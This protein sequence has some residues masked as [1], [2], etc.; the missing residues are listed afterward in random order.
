MT[1]VETLAKVTV[2]LALVWI[3]AA[4]LRRQSAAARHA[5]WAA[6]LIG[7]VLILVLE[8]APGYNLLPAW[9][10]VVQ[11]PQE[12]PKPQSLPSPE[13]LEGRVAAQ[14]EPG[15]MVELADTIATRA[16]GPLGKEVDRGVLLTVEPP[17]VPKQAPRVVSG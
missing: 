15:R 9:S 2:F 13:E 4:L 12:S 1:V 6:G 8:F 5:V 11:K 14:P 16:R 17:A 10:E 3:A 7:A